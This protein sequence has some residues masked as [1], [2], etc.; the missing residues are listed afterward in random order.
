MLQYR[1]SILILYDILM[2][3]SAVFT[4]MVASY[5]MAYLL[6]SSLLLLASHGLLLTTQ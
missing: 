2:F 5:K 6:L 4:F 3:V 1:S